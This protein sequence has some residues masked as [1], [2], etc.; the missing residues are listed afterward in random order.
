MVKGLYGVGSD[1]TL[2]NEHG[3]KLAKFPIRISSF[4]QRV[5]HKV[6]WMFW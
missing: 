6:F 5:Q 3:V 2:F 4:I 1:G